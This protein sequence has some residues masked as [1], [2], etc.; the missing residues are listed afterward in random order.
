MLFFLFYPL[1]SYLI[2]CMCGLI[3]INPIWMTSDKGDVPQ[4]F[5]RVADVVDVAKLEACLRGNQILVML[6]RSL[7]CPS[8]ILVLHLFTCRASNDSVVHTELLSKH[9]SCSSAHGQAHTESALTKRHSLT[10]NWN[11]PMFLKFLACLCNKYC[12]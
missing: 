10:L 7:Q 11:G 3:F 5:Q 2:P 4:L 6:Y 8:L 9:W 12:D 1:R